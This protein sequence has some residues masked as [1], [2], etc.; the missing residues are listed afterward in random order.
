MAYL[1]RFGGTDG[2]PFFSTNGVQR[3]LMKRLDLGPSAWDVEGCTGLRRRAAVVS[4]VALGRTCVAVVASLLVVVLTAKPKTSSLTKREY[5]LG[6]T[7]LDMAV[8]IVSGDV[9]G[10]LGSCRA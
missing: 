7:V 3:N 6:P 9:F 1:Y 4:T 8:A 5:E 2:D 10:F